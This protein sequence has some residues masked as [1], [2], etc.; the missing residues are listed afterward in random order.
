MP[1]RKIRKKYNKIIIMSGIFWLALVGALAAAMMMILNAQVHDSVLKT[2][3]Q[4]AVSWSQNLFASTPNAKIMFMGGRLSR[5]TIEK[6]EASFAL[7]SVVRFKTFDSNGRQTFI[8]DAGVLPKSPEINAKALK[9]FQ[10]GE[11]QSFTSDQPAADA[12]GKELHFAE[13]YAPAILPS[14][15][16]IGTI[17]VYL[18]VTELEK[19]LMSAFNR[20]TLF[21]VSATSAILLI[22]AAAFIY[23]TRQL[24]RKDK[25]LLE[26]SRFDQLTGVL[27]R[28]AIATHLDEIFETPQRHEQMG[29]LFIDLDRFK[30]VND[31]F[32]HHCGDAM[33]RHVA[34]ILLGAVNPETDV[35][36][37]YGGDEFVVLCPD[38]DPEYLSDL[39]HSILAATEDPV[40]HG[41]L[42]HT[43]SLSIG[44]Y[45]TTREDT[46]RTA[47]HRADLALY[48]AKKNG[49]GRAVTFSPAIEQKFL[50]LK[51][52]A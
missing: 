33:L 35:V 20:L 21:L 37:R 16:R 5:L 23:R 51:A 8:S 18:D 52:S 6:L 41:K 28:N 24:M 38:A 4:R 3:E 25:E 11:T 34:G 31:E 50:K 49:R 26:L 22:P 19:A 44:C 30:E 17:E 45:I 39:C 7:A 12:K 32:G 43:A 40:E 2:A 14:G 27:N 48:E 47:L 10:T 42:Q 36:G 15:E 9:V 1:Q 29:I 13:V 46:E